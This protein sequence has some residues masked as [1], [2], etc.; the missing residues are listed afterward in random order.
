MVVISPSRRINSVIG[1]SQRQRRLISKLRRSKNSSANFL[2]SAV[3]RPVLASFS[4]FNV[5]KA[6]VTVSLLSYVKVVVK[7]FAICVT[8]SRST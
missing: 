5:S 1:I 8:A 6:C 2:F 3:A 7:P 4:V